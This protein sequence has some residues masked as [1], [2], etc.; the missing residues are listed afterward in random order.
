MSFE[1]AGWVHLGCDAGRMPTAEKLRV[2]APPIVLPLLAR[3]ES[4][5]QENAKHRPRNR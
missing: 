1:L 3:T 4:K 5:Q 2:S